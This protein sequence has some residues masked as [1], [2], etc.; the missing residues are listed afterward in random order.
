MSTFSEMAERWMREK[1]PSAAPDE[2][3]VADLRLPLVSWL[4]TCCTVNSLCSGGL[5]CLYR[6]FCDWCIAGDLVPCDCH[7]F[8]LMLVELSFQIGVVSGTT[9]VLSLTLKDAVH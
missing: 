2:D 6:S 9:I 4:D 5:T 1:L 3:L 7:M 8:E